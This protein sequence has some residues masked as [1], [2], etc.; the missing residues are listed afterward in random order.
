MFPL[1]LHLSQVDSILLCFQSTHHSKDPLLVV[2]CPQ[3][4]SQGMEDQRSQHLRA[5]L[6]RK[7]DTYSCVWSSA[8]LAPPLPCSLL[9]ISFRRR[10][11][12]QKYQDRLHPVCL[13][14]R[15][16]AH[17][18]QT[19]FPCTKP[20]GQLCFACIVCWSPQSLLMLLWSKSTPM[21]VDWEW[22]IF[23]LN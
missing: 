17:S 12:D 11:S 16:A 9:W 21:G 13:Q 10:I 19:V 18:L 23:Y 3:S 22:T 5:I 20:H 1:L 7:W 14:K 4:W 8:V 6:V 2:F 15:T